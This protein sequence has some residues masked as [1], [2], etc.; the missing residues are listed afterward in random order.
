MIN[1]WYTTSVN[2]PWHMVIYI[3]EY[4]NICGF[5]GKGVPPIPTFW[6][7][8]LTNELWIFG[9]YNRYKLPSGFIKRCKCK[10]TR[11]CGFN[12]KITY[13]QCISIAMFDYRRVHIWVTVYMG[14]CWKGGTL[15]FRMFF[16][17]IMIREN[18]GKSIYTW[19]MTGGTPI[20]GNLHI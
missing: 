8:Y 5:P 4:K 20:S 13:R 10:S 2:N 3:D 12:R 6:V 11:N 7:Y 14:V 9:W 16:F 19:M 17:Q 15:L 1:N 18:H